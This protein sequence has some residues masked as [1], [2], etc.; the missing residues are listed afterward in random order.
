MKIYLALLTAVL[1]AGCSKQD[2]DPV[3]TAQSADAAKPTAAEMDMSSTEHSQM[4]NADQ[5]AMSDAEHAQMS[6]S[7]TTMGTDAPGAGTSATATGTVDKTDAAA[8]T[9][10]IS[11]DPVEALKWPAMTMAF[12]ATPEQVASVQAGQK[13]SF[14][15]TS[16]GKDANITMIKS[17]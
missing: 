2:A 3:D 7:N 10:T 13:V 1:A 8:G 14:E 17:Q 5:M 16:S 15:F 4:A 6:A 9:I 12:K 11:H